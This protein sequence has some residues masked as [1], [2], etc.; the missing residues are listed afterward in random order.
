MTSWRYMC[1]LEPYSMSQNCHSR[2]QLRN[3]KTVVCTSN[4]N[5]VN[6]ISISWSTCGT[7]PF[8]SS[9]NCS[10]INAL[11][12]HKLN[13]CNFNNIF[14]FHLMILCQPNLNP[15][16]CHVVYIILKANMLLSAL[17]ACD[18][19]FSSV[20]SKS[21]I[22]S[23]YS[24]FRCSVMTACCCYKKKKIKPTGNWCI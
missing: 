13:K 9:R 24:T 1:L 22:S 5:A 20:W 12:G 19:M 16:I 7:I 11:W 14:L 21:R 10:C 6:A 23:P 18:W 17:L 2:H 15:C 3:T 8:Y 4:D